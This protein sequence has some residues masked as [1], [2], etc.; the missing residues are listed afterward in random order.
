MAYLFWNIAVFDDVAPRF[1]FP[2][3]WVKGLC[4]PNSA[5]YEGYDE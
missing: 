2:K 3:V 1:S 5:A 4:C